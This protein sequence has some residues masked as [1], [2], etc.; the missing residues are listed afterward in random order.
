MLGIDDAVVDIFFRRATLFSCAWPRYS[1]FRFGG[2]PKILDG[3]MIE[4][5][6]IS[7]HAGQQHT[8]RLAALPKHGDLG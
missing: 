5:V 4:I 6:V 8:I 3:L 7:N 2:V 1:D